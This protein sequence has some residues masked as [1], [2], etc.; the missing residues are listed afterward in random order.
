MKGLCPPPPGPDLSAD[1][2]DHPEDPPHLLPHGH[3][4]RGRH[5]HCHGCELGGHPWVLG[6]VPSPGGVWCAQPRGGVWVPEMVPRPRGMQGVGA[7]SGCPPQSGGRGTWVQGHSTHPMVRVQGGGAPHHG[8]GV[9]SQHPPQ[10]GLG[11]QG[12]MGAGGCRVRVLPPH[13]D[14]AVHPSLGGWF[15]VPT[16]LR[17]G[18]P[19]PTPP[20]SSWVA[21][22]S[23][24]TTAPP[25]SRPTR[26]ARSR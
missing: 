14:G 26:C 15:W 12:D 22:A 7:G 13:C 1:P 4:H 23:S 18:D 3:R 10:P 11:V 19:H 25:S 2:Q 9:G 8:K 6:G 24:T 16:P 21:L 20:H 5:G 17:E